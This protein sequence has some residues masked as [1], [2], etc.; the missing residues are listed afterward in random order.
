MK[1][2]GCLIA[3]T[4]VFI[5]KAP[6]VSGAFFYFSISSIDSP[7]TPRQFILAFQGRV[8]QEDDFLVFV[9]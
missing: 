2:I 6:G 1:I 4:I 3:N 8:C 5:K 9:A 7:D